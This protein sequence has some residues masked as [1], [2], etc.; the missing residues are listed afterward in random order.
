MVVYKNI[1]IVE[2]LLLKLPVFNRTSQLGVVF[3]KTD[4]GEPSGET[5]ST[6]MFS[7]L[8]A[9]TSLILLTFVKSK[10]Y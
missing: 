9:I 8:S 1:K 2:L 4:L 3:T 10:K 5:I 6:D 7:T